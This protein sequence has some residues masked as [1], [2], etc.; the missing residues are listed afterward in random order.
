[1]PYPQEITLEG[2]NFVSLG[3]VARRL[4]IA[5]STATR[6]CRRGYLDW[7]AH[8][9]Y[10]L[11]AGRDVHYVTEKSLRELEKAAKK[12]V[13]KGGRVNPKYPTW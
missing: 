9:I 10:S 1:M 4:G 5:R 8:P 2:R 3:V 7:M 6:I 12:A 11:M 13:K